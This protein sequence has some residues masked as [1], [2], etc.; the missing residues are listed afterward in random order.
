M[1]PVSINSNFLLQ[2]NKKKIIGIVY[3]K[4]SKI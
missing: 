4:Y 3:N 1:V 2:E